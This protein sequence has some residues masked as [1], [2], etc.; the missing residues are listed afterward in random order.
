ML[1]KMMPSEMAEEHVRMLL[2]EV[3]RLLHWTGSYYEQ[4]KD[5]QQPV[6]RQQFLRDMPCLILVKISD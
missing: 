4:R 2:G 6:T 5:Q 1:T 3:M